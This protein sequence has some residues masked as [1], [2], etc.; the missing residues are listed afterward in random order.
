MFVSE[1]LVIFFIKFSYLKGGEN[2]TL[3]IFKITC[4]HRLMFFKKLDGFFYS[5]AAW[6][7]LFLNNND[8]VFLHLAFC[9]PYLGLFFKFQTLRKYQADLIN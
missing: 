8:P 5:L 1:P 3:E 6:P 2:W 7:L 4:C 9:N